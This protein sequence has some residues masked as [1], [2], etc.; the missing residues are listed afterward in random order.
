MI[1][2]STDA[3]KRSRISC[4]R[5]RSARSSFAMTVSGSYKKLPELAITISRIAAAAA[6]PPIAK[7]VAARNAPRPGGRPPV[8]RVVSDPSSPDDGS[9]K[10]AAIDESSAAA[11]AASS[12]GRGRKSPA[13]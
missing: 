13:S 4:C 6:L 1:S 12:A 5:R 3:A 8:G 7:Y 2:E 11:I 9:K 10:N